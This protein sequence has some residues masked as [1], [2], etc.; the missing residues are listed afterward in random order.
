M[1]DEFEFLLSIYYKEQ[2]KTN[3]SEKYKC[4]EK[5]LSELLIDV[6]NNMNVCEK[7]AIGYPFCDYHFQPVRSIPYKRKWHFMTCLRK[8]GFAIKWHELDNL[9]SKFIK[10]DRAYTKYFPNKNMVNLNFVIKYISLQL[11][12][13][14][15]AEKIKIGRT[16]RTKMNWYNKL[17]LVLS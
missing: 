5:C 10:L 13:T 11:G 6:K 17:N 14:H 9:L 8:M 7:C 2:E 12:Y 1:D 3:R 15:I 4:C 16:A